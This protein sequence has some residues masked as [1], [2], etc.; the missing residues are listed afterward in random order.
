MGIA[1]ALALDPRLLI[2]DEPVSALDVSIQASVLNLLVDLKRSEGI[3]YLF[4]THNLAVA[5]YIAD[6]VAVVYAGRVMEV[7]TSDDVIG[8]PLH[9]YTR[10]LLAAVPGQRLI[11]ADGLGT[12][13]GGA[14]PIGGV[15]CP[16]RNRCPLATEV[17]TTTTPLLEQKTQLRLVACHHVDVD[18][19]PSHV[20]AGR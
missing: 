6:R 12:G 18:I 5:Q 14:P 7:G 19:A 15:G 16:Y 3:S 20:A 11:D 8:S 4:I 10:E 1:R 2:A 13:T 9:P 17:C